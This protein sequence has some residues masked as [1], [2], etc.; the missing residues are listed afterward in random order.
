[1]ITLGRGVPLVGGGIGGT[2]D[3]VATQA[4]GK[5]AD[6]FFSPAA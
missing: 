6:K 2:V 4:V 5:F 1:M 3:A